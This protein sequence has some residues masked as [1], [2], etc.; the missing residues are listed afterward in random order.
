MDSILIWLKKA[1]RRLR[2]EKGVGLVEVLVAI[3]ILGGVAV[4][5]LNAD[6]TAYRAIT[7]ANELA[8][9]QRSSQL[10]MDYYKRPIEDNPDLET[11]RGR[12]P[13]FTFPEPTIELRDTFTNDQTYKLEKITVTVTKETRPLPLITLEGYR[14]VVIE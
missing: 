4:V 2:D 11:I 9:A 10:V 1:I 14:I 13:T 7:E 6:S 5:Y 12:Y 3:V 8:V